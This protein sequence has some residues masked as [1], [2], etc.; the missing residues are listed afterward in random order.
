MRRLLPPNVEKKSFLIEV[1][2]DYYRYYS[3]LY[4]S[5]CILEG[6]TDITLID[7]GL[8]K[9]CEVRSVKYKVV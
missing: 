8:P 1:V 9:I 5:L 7:Y 4:L 2:Q 3:S 6:F